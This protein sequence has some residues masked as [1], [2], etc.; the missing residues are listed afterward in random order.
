MSILNGFSFFSPGFF[1]RPA[2]TLVQIPQ[3]NRHAPQCFCPQLSR[4]HDFGLGVT[5]ANSFLE[6]SFAQE[7]L[8]G[9]DDALQAALEASVT[10]FRRVLMTG[11]PLAIIIGMVPMALG[12]GEG[13]E[14]KAPLGRAV[15]GGLIVATCATLFLVSCR[16]QHRPWRKIHQFGHQQNNPRRRCLCLMNFYSENLI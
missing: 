15:I 11:A 4:A 3:G 8:A 13:G 7:Q 14:Q 16:L 10:R 5:T 6:V 12:L 2:P 9:T 1:Q